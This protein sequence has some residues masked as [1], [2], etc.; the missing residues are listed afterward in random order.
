MLILTYL[1]P[2]EIIEWI[3]N[4]FSNLMGKWFHVSRYSIIGYILAVTI[5]LL[6]SF[7][8]IGVEKVIISYHRTLIAPIFKKLFKYDNIG[9]PSLRSF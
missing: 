9:L 1:V 5:G 8:F 7:S 4:S 3:Q 2:N 6:V